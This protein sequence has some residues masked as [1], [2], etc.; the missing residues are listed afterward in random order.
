MS[1]DW[2]FGPTL[3][4]GEGPF[5]ADALRTLAS[6]GR[7]NPDD[8]VWRGTTS[9]SAR[10]S[11]VKGLF[12]S[13]ALRF[14]CGSCQRVIVAQPRLAGK[15]AICPGCGKQVQVPNRAQ[16]SIAESVARRDNTSTTS[17]Q[18]EAQPQYE[19]VVGCQITPDEYSR[20][21]AGVSAFAPV[22]REAIVADALL[23]TADPTALPTGREIIEVD[24]EH[25]C[26]SAMIASHPD[27]LGPQATEVARGLYEGIPFGATAD[28]AAQIIGPRAIRPDDTD[29]AEDMVTL[30]RLPNKRFGTLFSGVVMEPELVFSRSVR[31]FCLV[32]HF[33]ICRG[34]GDWKYEIVVKHLNDKMGPCSLR[35][36]N[37]MVR[38]MAWLKHGVV[39][40][41]TL[42]AMPLTGD[43]W[44]F[45]T[46]FP[47]ADDWRYVFGYAQHIIKDAFLAFRGEITGR[48]HFLESTQGRHTYLIGDETSDEGG[49][50]E[51]VFDR[52]RAFDG[53]DAKA[54]ESL[55]R[56]RRHDDRNG[57]QH[58]QHLAS[59]YKRL[60][61]FLL[62]SDGVLDCG[63][64]EASE[65][66]G[67]FVDRHLAIRATAGVNKKGVPT[68]NDSR[69]VEQN[70]SDLNRLIGLH[71]VKQEVA[72]LVAFLKVQGIR[73]ERGMAPASISRH[74]V[75]Y[76]NPGTGKT[77]VARLLSKIYSSLGFLS[78]G[79]LVEADRSGLVAGF[80]GQTAIKTREACEKALGGVLFIDE[81]YTLVGKENDYGQEAIDT[82]LKFM[83]DNRDDLVVVVAGYPEKMAGFLDSNPG[84]RSRFTR[85][86]NFQD[87]SP[88]ELSSIFMG[89]CKEGGFSLSEGASSKAQGIFEE[90]FLQRDK[91]FGNARFAR[92]LFEQCLVHHARRI[93]KTDHITDGM[94]TML[95]EGDVACI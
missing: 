88:D 95:E 16:E 90:Q 21:I 52:A 26:A 35:E 13:P 41:A 67:G 81:A 57:T 94:L 77:T 6:Q 30:F 47:F 29:D 31:R 20:F 10:A 54:P 92:N 93:T 75:F 59:I 71:A 83:E 12:S 73:K 60:F 1:V 33:Q 56:L 69:T 7:I 45:V 61:A 24:L 63:E 91:T 18:A 40:E 51:R 68:D 2:F 17:G 46:V 49:F 65:A 39:T 14:A 66:F 76:G 36:D 62:R 8:W 82:L 3:G 86:M 89:F 48:T 55:I 11:Q 79:H 44:L 53:I 74:L 85:F 42:R 70:L 28:Q 37:D 87:Y 5:D 22:F 34:D 9:K 25:F 78:K 15:T 19:S 43:P 64:Q 27:I 4:D 80:V 50:C 32:R 72:D 23:Q 84:I 58:A 38:K